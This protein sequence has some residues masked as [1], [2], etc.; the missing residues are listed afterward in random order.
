MPTHPNQL[1][2]LLVAQKELRERV[3]AIP[4]ECLDEQDGVDLFDWHE[5]GPAEKSTLGNAGA[6]DPEPAKSNLDDRNDETRDHY[7][8]GG[9]YPRP[10]STGH[11]EHV[12]DYRRRHQKSNNRSCTTPQDFLVRSDPVKIC[13]RK[14]LV[15]RL[16]HL[17]L[18]VTVCAE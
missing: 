12:Q 14:V 1:F 5:L 9:E 13:R 3:Y 10:R 11:R 2:A 18:R 15:S 6:T 4:L 16:T 8:L 7:E 17:T